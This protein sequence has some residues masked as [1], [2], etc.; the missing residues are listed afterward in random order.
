MD[1]LQCSQAKKIQKNTL[2]YLSEAKFILKE[3]LND[4]KLP[5]LVS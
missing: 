2:V 3:I 5:S 1:Y 4:T